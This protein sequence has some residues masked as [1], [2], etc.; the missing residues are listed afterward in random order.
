MS[1]ITGSHGASVIVCTYSR[2]YFLILLLSYPVSSPLLKCKP[3]EG[4][5]LFSV[6][7]A[8]ISPVLRK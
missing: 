5:K 2:F 4:S 6:L 3:H 8:A 1:G 7:F